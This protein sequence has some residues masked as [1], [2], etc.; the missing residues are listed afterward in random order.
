MSPTQTHLKTTYLIKRSLELDYQLTG[1]QRLKKNEIIDFIFKKYSLI[2]LG[3]LSKVSFHHPGKATVFGYQYWY[4]DK[5]GLAL[6]QSIYV[7]NAFLANYCLHPNVVV[8]VGA[9]TGQFNFFCKHYLDAKRVYSFQPIRDSFKILDINTNS[10]NVFPYAILPTSDATF[11]VPDKLNL[12]AS[13][14]KLGQTL[15]TEKITAQKLDSVKEIA[16]E[17]K[18]DL[19]KI[20]TEGSELDVLKTATRTLRKTKHLLIECSLSRPNLGNLTQVANFLYNLNHFEI[21]YIGRKYLSEKGQVDAVDVLFS[22][23]L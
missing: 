21:V 7:D 1:I 18:I 13:A 17:Q 12:M 22:S 10:K 11:F 5:N 19:F 8:D 4:P 23:A 9:N 2:I 14:I 6:L 3:L 16:Q 15:R 20:D